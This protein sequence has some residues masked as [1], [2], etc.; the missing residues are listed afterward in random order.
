MVSTRDK[1]KKSLSNLKEKSKASHTMTFKL[2]Q[3]Q[4]SE[5]LLFK[6]EKEI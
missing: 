2:L 3:N 6:K 4:K 5:D 1:T